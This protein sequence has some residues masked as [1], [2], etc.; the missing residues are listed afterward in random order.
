MPILQ[1][2]HI[3]YYYQDGDTKRNIIQDISIDFEKGKMYAI[4]GSSGSGK[5]TFLSLLG[6]LDQPKSG[7]IYYEGTDIETIGLEQYRRNKISIIFQSYNIIPYMTALENVMVAMHFT[8]NAIPK[9]QE[10]VATN[11][12]DFIGISKDKANRLVTQL[13]GGEQQRV[14]IARSL[15]TNVDVI[16]ADEPTGNLDENTEA[17]IIEVF[18]TLAHEHNKLVIVVTHS[19]EIARHADVVLEL[20]Q[21]M[22]VNG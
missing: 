11:L 6:A 8:E 15:A 7:K 5:T 13:S 16:L 12:L 22:F 2:E 20:K 19:Q 10:K 17:D 14:A 3:N 18:Q 21:G 1:T 9:D 4:L